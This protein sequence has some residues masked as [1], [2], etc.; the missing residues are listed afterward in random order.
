MFSI[1]STNRKTCCCTS[2]HKSG[3][4][5]IEKEKRFWYAFSIILNEDDIRKQL[6][7]LGLRPEKLRRD[8]EIKIDI[9]IE[10][11]RKN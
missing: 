10:E 7:E 2:C 9:Y 6:S 5:E 11:T 4:K 8:Q 1:Q 3:P